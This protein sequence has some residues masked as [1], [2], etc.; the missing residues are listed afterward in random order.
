MK[1]LAVVISG[2]HFPL[3]FFQKIAEQK[4]PDGWSVDLFCISHRDPGFS[5]EEKKGIP[6][7]LGYARRELFDRILYHKIATVEDITALGWQ[8]V[9]EPNTIGDWGNSNQWLEKHNFR[10]YDKFLF[11]HDDNFILTDHMFMDILPQEDWLILANSTGNA[12]RRLRQLFGLSKPLSIRGSFEFF[13]KEMIEVLGGRFDLSEVKLERAGQTT[14]T[15]AFT[16]LSDWNNTVTPLTTL[17]RE[18]KLNSQV[19][20]L[21]P[22]YRMST[23]CLEGERGFIHKT[24]PS[25][26]AEEERGLDAIERFYARK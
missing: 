12:Q 16:E 13:T 1:H 6:D 4:I 24:E 8:Y 3:H 20:A 26:T 23:Y 10:K 11:S 14:T 5:A 7:T 17:I 18:R 19:H 25:N 9:L 22:F 21:S 15:G 2:W